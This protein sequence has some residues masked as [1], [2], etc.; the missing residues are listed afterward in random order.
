M[1]IISLGS[2]YSYGYGF[3]LLPIFLLCG[4]AVMAYRIAVSINFLF[5]FLTFIYL[6]R[7]I[8]RLFPDESIPVE[9][10]SGLIILFP[11]NLFYAQMTMTEILLLF[12]YVLAGLLLLDYM[13]NNSKFVLCVLLITLMYS[14]MVHMR[15]IGILLSAVCVLV[16]H[17][18]S[19]KGNKFHVLI[20]AGMLLLLFAIER[21]LKNWAFQSV[22]GNVGQE[23]IQG[24]DY[25]GQMDKIR[26]IFTS[27]GLYDVIISVWGK[28][29]YLGLSTYGLFYFGMAV[30]I[31]KIKE[32]AVAIKCHTEIAI[33]QKFFLFVFLSVIAQILIA[34]VY[35]LTLGEISDY[36]YGR[37]T[38]LIIPFVMA[39]G[40]VELWNQ[41][42]KS[43]IVFTGSM[44]VMQ[45]ICTLLVVRQ[46]VDTG[47]ET[48]HGFFMIGIS[49]LY[50]EGNFNCNNFYRNAYFLCEALTIFVVLIA[51]WCRKSKKRYFFG[52]GIA[53]LEL[54][55]AMRAT[56]I[57]LNPLQK[58]VF[59]DIRIAEKA[60]ALWK[61]GHQV[62]YFDDTFPVYVGILQFMERSM[63]IQVTKVSDA[64]GGSEKNMMADD[65][66][67]LAFDSPNVQR[68]M[69]LFSNVY[70]YGHF[71][72]LY[73][74]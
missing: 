66:L 49:Y 74:D 55:L 36:T 59:R 14:Y 33:S 46:I 31:K 38:E 64:I 40:I 23:L 43:V 65:V 51:F 26:Y 71:T 70:T 11:G 25:G 37:Y 5:L 20:L 57:F 34:T 41:R 27:K 42:K 39:L 2:Y 6:I 69:E 10:F 48:F 73:N 16:V 67:I 58:A 56:T 50:K 60:E 54:V 3:V 63:E 44:A 19:K 21:I 12:L 68:W 22:Y 47:A 18:W 52:A 61:E 53:I 4:D 29:L 9:L 13:K 24:N 35:L 8:R 62:I 17:I 7:I 1:D 72:L 28:V 45:A 30:V 32:M 15:T